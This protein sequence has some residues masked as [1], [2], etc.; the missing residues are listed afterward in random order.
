MSH[1][2]DGADSWGLEIILCLLIGLPWYGFSRNLLLAEFV[3]VGLVAL[4][5][6]LELLIFGRGS[7]IMS[8]L[9]VLVLSVLAGFIAISINGGRLGT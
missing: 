2:N 7:A 1:S 4:F 5:L 3:H 9:F 6:L 8:F